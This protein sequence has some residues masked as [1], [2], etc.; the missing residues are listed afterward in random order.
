[1]A[2]RSH[3]TTVMVPSNKKFIQ[4]LEFPISVD[5]NND[6]KVKDEVVVINKGSGEYSNYWTCPNYFG[7]VQIVLDMCQKAKFST[8]MSFL[9]LFK[10]IWTG[11]KHFGPA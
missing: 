6:I 9:D 1:M 4:K 10:L 5:T 7:H 11:P 8:A 2:C 3:E